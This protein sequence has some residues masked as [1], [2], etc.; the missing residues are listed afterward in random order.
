MVEFSEVKLLPHVGSAYTGLEGR[1]IKH[2]FSDAADLLRKIANGLESFTIEMLTQA[3]R[4]ATAIFFDKITRAV[5]NVVY[6]DDGHSAEFV[7]HGWGFYQRTL[8]LI[9]SH[10]MVVRGTTYKTLE[11]EISA[12]NDDVDYALW[13]HEGHF[14]VSHGRYVGYVEGRPWFPIGIEKGED[15]AINVIFKA[16]EKI[17]G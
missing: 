15:R 13:V 4:K 1:V 7:Y 9:E 16:V 11:G 2:N 10:R 8:K 17:F 12:G 5:W 6:K 14:V 3:L